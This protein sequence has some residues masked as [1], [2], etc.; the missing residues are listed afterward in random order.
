MDNWEELSQYLRERS[1]EICKDNGCGE[2]HWCDSYAYIT[3]SGELLDVCV[4]DYFSGM[5]Q[6]VAIPLPWE[7]DGEELKCLVQEEIWEEEAWNSL[8]S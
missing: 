1:K 5:E 7:G 4:P 3:K 6:C 8:D 2:E